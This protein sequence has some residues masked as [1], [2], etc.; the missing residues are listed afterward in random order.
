[1]GR[2]TVDTAYYR[3]INIIG[4]PD[5]IG[6]NV[7]AARGH[8]PIA[9]FVCRIQVVKTLVPP[10]HIQGIAVRQEGHAPQSLDPIRHNPGKVGPEESHVSRL[11]KMDFNG[12]VFLFEINLLNT[13]FNNQPIQFVQQTVADP[14]TH[15]GKVHL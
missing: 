9:V 2:L 3:H 10:P 13:R 8:G 11:S 12:N 7:L 6:D 1:V 14:T 4:T 5:T 15:I